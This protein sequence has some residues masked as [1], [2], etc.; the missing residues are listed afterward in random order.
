MDTEYASPRPPFDVRR[1]LWR[2][3]AIFP[4]AVA[5]EAVT[6]HARFDAPPDAVWRGLMFYE[7]VPHRPPL[8][9]RLFLPT[10]VATEGNDKRVG[11]V[12][13]CRYSSGKLRKR[14]TAL[15]PPSLVRFEVIDQRLGVEHCVTTVEGSYQI[16][17]DGDGSEVA[18][19]TVYR[20]HL[21]PRR[22]W[23]PFER[24]LAHQL[25]RHIL[26]GMG[27]APKK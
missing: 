16:R 24:L 20:G 21:R 11:T 12:V 15:E 18:L 2:L 7:E 6:T 13:E 27:A 22:L 19:T 10:P 14:F 9:L 5:A 8:L 4:P 25:H 1:W 23:R 17:A 3:G 26:S